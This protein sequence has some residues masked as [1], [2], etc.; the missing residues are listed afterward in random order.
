MAEHGHVHPPSHYIK[1]WGILM[2]LLVVSVVGPMA[3]IWWLTLITAF[4]IAFVKASIVLKYFMHIDGEGKLVWY[5]LTS[6]VLFMIIF[7]FGV[8]PDVMNHEGSRWE[9]VA[10]KQW[11]EK[12]LEEGDGHGAHGGGHG[13]HDDHGAEHAEPAHDDKGHEGGH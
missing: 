7:F 2:G 5:I 6:S 8:A 10:A 11:V 12:G 4:G 13:G 1:I 3:E 9:N